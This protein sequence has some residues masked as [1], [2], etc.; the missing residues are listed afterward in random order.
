LRLLDLQVG[1]LINFGAPTFKQGVK[2]VVNKHCDF[3]ASRLRVNL[4][5]GLTRIR[6]QREEAAQTNADGADSTFRPA[7]WLDGA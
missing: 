4:Q 5:A 3:A 7:S 2:R 6:E 1:L